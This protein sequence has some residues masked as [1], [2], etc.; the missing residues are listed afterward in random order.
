MHAISIAYT[1][2]EAPAAA[3]PNNPKL[4]DLKSI[5]ASFARFGFVSPEC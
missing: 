3:G 4:H 2:L 5:R 1:T